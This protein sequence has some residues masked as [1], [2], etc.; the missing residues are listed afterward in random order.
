MNAEVKDFV[1]KCSTCQTYQPE[2]CREPLQ[3][4]PIP[5]RPWSVV[6]EDLFQLGQQHFLIVVDYWSGFFEVQEL[7]KVTSKSVINASKVQFA[8]HGIRQTVISDNGPQF[9]WVEFAQFALEWQFHHQT[10]SPNYPQ[11]NGRAENA[12][13]TCKKPNEKS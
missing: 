7:S 1:S 11:S 3:P 2:Q 13:K 4:Y 12:V 5:L 6:G 10:S 9:A 8:R